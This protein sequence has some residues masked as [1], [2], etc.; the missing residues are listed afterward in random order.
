MWS[1]IASIVMFMQVQGQGKEVTEL[2]SPPTYDL[3]GF[4]KTRDSA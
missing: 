1:D 4:G 2:C 3:I